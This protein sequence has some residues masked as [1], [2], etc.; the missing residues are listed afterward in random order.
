MRAQDQ[1]K[2][3]AGTL[4]KQLSSEISKGL[5]SISQN[6]RKGGA[7][8]ATSLPIAATP[9]PAASETLSAKPSGSGL[10]QNCPQKPMQKYPSGG[11]TRAT[12]PML[13][14]PTTAA[15]SGRLLLAAGTPARS[16]SLPTPLALTYSAATTS[17]TQAL[18]S[19]AAALQVE[20]QATFWKEAF[21]DRIDPS[22]ATWPWHRGQARLGHPIS[23]S[24]GVED[25]AHCARSQDC[26]GADEADIL[27]DI[28]TTKH[29]PLLVTGPGT[30]GST[31]DWCLSTLAI[32]TSRWLAMSSVSR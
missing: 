25:Y 20:P 15:R 31:D 1:A 3:N 32:L 21:C 27:Q 4:A 12:A 2:T 8:L 7:V 5:Q 11:S 30:N 29:G 14:R 10:R 26:G 13:G 18:R 23:R 9:N 6:F 19:F 16:N 22:I 17:E 24:R 28:H